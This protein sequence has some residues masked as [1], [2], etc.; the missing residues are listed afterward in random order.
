MLIE[1]AFSKFKTENY[2]ERRGKI[3]FLLNLFHEG[4][5]DTIDLRTEDLLNIHIGSV[6]AKER[7]QC[8][9]RTTCSL[10]MTNKGYF[11]E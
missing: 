8:I 9:N 1:K 10:V 2:I 5:D 4:H 11:A 7:L 6:L 3:I